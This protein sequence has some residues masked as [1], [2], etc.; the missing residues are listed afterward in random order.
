M[1]PN[2]IF[3]RQLF[4]D[5]DFTEERLETEEGLIFYIS[6]VLNNGTMQ[7]IREM[8]EDLIQRYLPSLHLSRTVRNYWEWY[9]EV[10]SSLHAFSRKKRERLLEASQI[11][12]T[13]PI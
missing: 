4:W 3:D 11:A 6:R 2:I 13:F 8:P 9:F 1:K 5:Y 12:W 7:H 10:D